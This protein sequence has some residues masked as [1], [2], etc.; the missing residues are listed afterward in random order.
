MAVWLSLTR[1]T[2]RGAPPAAPGAFTQ[3]PQV[4]ARPTA[5][6]AR[7]NAPA[8]PAIT[9]N[10]PASAQQPMLNGPNRPVPLQGGGVVT[11]TTAVRNPAD[12]LRDMGLLDLKWE[13]DDEAVAELLRMLILKGFGPKAGKPKG[14]SE[15][16]A[17]LAD[18]VRELQTATGLPPSGALDARTAAAVM[19][20]LK[21][22]AAREAPPPPVRVAP[23][24]AQVQAV[25][26]K[27]TAADTARADVLWQKTQG[28]A[29]SSAR[30][31]AFAASSLA[32]AAPPANQAPVPANTV[33]LNAAASSASATASSAPIAPGAPPPAPTTL[34][35]NTLHGKPAAPPPPAAPAVS[36]PLVSLASPARPAPSSAGAPAT[37]PPATTAPPAT[38]S[39]ATAAATANP[40]SGA[41]SSSRTLAD[42]AP[43]TVSAREAAPP[44][45]PP[46]VSAPGGPASAEVKP[47]GGAPD[48]SLA[49]GDS[50]AQ[51]GHQ[52]GQGNQATG[53]DRLEDAR[54]GHA[55]V[56]DGS[57]VDAGAYEMPSLD[58][59]LR[60]AL[61]AFRREESQDERH[62]TT[63]TASFVL[64]KPG[65][66]ASATLAPCLL[67]LTVDTATAYDEVWMEALEK[68][69]K[70]VRRHDPHSWPLS[71]DDILSALQRARAR[72]T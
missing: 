37:P 11:T 14:G 28:T 17:Q 19:E 2:I 58:E 47:A 24:A 25:R 68:I 64:H 61:D 1:M 21:P 31:A 63:Y 66:Y 16:A 69:N 7:P 18:A 30:A 26:Q 48:G 35:V 59:Q 5:D 65:F 9:P 6:A 40:V 45:D 29:Y 60:A 27:T 70:V 15:T 57:G 71:V 51:R 3:A 41:A 32:D 53:D 34:A 42:P 44:Q 22:D 10:A 23:S 39:T 43:G 50:E 46:P 4:A 67:N 38:V 52:D 72:D 20:K 55:L 56:D 62:T 13:H 36:N 12:V 49:R 33:R 8:A 54:R